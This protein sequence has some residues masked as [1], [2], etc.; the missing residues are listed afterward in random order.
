MFPDMD[1]EEATVELRSGDVPSSSP[2]PTV[3]PR[4]TILLTFIVMKVR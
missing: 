4:R 2:T 1:Y 3:S